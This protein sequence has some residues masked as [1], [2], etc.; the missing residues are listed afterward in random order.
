MRRLLPLLLVGAS[1]WGTTPDRLF[2]PQGTGDG[3]LWGARAIWTA[4]VTVLPAELVATL[5]PPAVV[6]RPSRGRLVEGIPFS[7]TPGVHRRVPANDACAV[8]EVVAHLRYLASEVRRIHPG[9]PDMVV[10]DIARCG[11]GRFPPHRTHQNG[12]DVDLRYYQLGVA[13]GFY[14]YIFV[15]GTNFDTARVWALVETIYRQGLADDLLI[16]V[17][18]QRRLYRYARGQRGLSAE[19]VEPILSWPRAPHRDD[20]LVKHVRGHHNHLHIRFRTPISDLLGTLWTPQTADEWRRK[21]MFARTG[22]FDHVVQRGET[23]GT[24]AA[25]HQVELD[26]LMAWNRLKKRSVL[27]PGQ[28]VEIRAQ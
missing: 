11:G 12:R 4:L 14:D 1:A 8:P 6:G 25:R 17:R 2:V 22:R 24:I 26:D 9:G 7:P 3:I 15:N 28:V 19:E 18:H 20:A 23:L 5:H 21:L 10:G 16:D 27:R 13:E